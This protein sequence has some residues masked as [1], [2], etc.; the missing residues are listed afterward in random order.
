MFKILVW[1]KAKKMY[2]FLK[3]EIQE[4]FEQQL[5]ANNITK[6]NLQVRFTNTGKSDCCLSVTLKA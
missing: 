2:W 6:G 4:Q 1:C 3:I 5:F